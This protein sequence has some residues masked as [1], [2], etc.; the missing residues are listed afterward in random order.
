MT[1]RQVG[2]VAELWRYPV[3]SM[4]GERVAEVMVTERG[5]A[6]DR[7]WAMR[8][9]KYGG[10]MSARLFAAMLQLR[11]TCE[12]QPA[13]A[14]TPRVRIELPDGATIHAGDPG[15]DEILS[16]LF[17]FAVRLERP[18]E[19]PL[20]MEEIAAIRDGRAFLPPRDLYDEDVLHV[21]ASGTLAHL[22]QLRRGD[23]DFDV[24]R[25]RPNIYV[26]TGSRADCFVEDEWL[27]GE[28][29]IGADGMRVVGMR[30]ALR[31]ALTIHAQ[32]EFGPD[33]AI[34]RTAARHHDAYVGVFASVGAPGRI[35]IDDPV[36]LLTERSAAC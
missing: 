31:C 2:T 34:L 26:D 35:R 4:R 20:T 13:S 15:A 17:G 3:K 33:P 24:R 29:E 6:G 27:G 16:S 9:L 7:L 19:G 36:W 18:R 30:P 12:S 23:S 28:L 22:R 21:L 25:F 14:T 11:A 8:E 5:A 1:R 32:A 10:I